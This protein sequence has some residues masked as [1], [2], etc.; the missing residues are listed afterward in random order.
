MSRFSPDQMESQHTHTST[1]NLP[2][3]DQT[4]IYMNTTVCE[5]WQREDVPDTCICPR[6]YAN[7]CFSKA[8]GS[9][10]P[11]GNERKAL[12]IFDVTKSSYKAQ[13]LYVLYQ[14]A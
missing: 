14:L 3:L 11:E 13:L 5:Q 4:F 12:R 8:E 9:L 1:S 7:S 6:Q 10:K 2:L